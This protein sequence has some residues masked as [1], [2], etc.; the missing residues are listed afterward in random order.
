MDEGGT[1]EKTP[2]GSLTAGWAQ[3]RSDGRAWAGSPQSQR[4]LSPGS[5]P[6]RRS[7]GAIGHRRSRPTSGSP[8][9]PR[10]H[11]SHLLSRHPRRNLQPRSPIAHI[12]GWPRARSAGSAR[13][14]AGSACTRAGNACTRGGR[15]RTRAGSTAAPKRNG[16][17]PRPPRLPTPPRRSTRTSRPRL[18]A[19]STSSASAR[20][21]PASAS[22]GYRPAAHPPN[23]P[24]RAP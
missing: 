2:L 6:C 13:T 23:R 16:R 19:S 7:W 21:W 18:R 15:S 24:G 9:R 10:A 1:G 22:R 17:R 14:R 3:G 20:P 8:R 5:S 12:V 4:R 11:R